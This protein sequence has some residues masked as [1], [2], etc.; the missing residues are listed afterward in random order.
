MSNNSLIN[1]SPQNIDGNCDLKCSYSF[2]YSKTN[3]TIK[4]NDIMLTLTPDVATSTEVIFNDNK[5]N[6]SQ[7]NIYTPSLHLF[8]G[9][10]V[11][12]EIQVEH[13]PQSGGENLYICIPLV[14]GGDETE[15]S[16]LISKLVMHSSQRAPAKNETTN[17]NT[18]DFTLKS[19][20]PL[21]PFY[22]YTGVSNLPGQFI[23]YGMNNGIPINQKLLGILSKII[24]PY[25]LEMTGGKLFYNPK[26]PRSGYV[27][28]D[29]IYIS[30]KPTGSSTE[31]TT[32]ESEKTNTSNYNLGD[33]FKSDTF[34][35]I[36][37]IIMA[38][39]IFIVLIYGLNMG[40]TY[41]MTGEKPQL[42]MPSFSMNNK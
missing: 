7:I 15:A 11:A 23:V 28:G 12:G 10:K 17:L 14:N 21:K 25:N 34:K 33:I 24:K 19:I 22:N 9:R 3:L 27:G 37:Q 26:G 29:G 41:L 36:V 4:N 8:N 18:N 30:C 38:S 39:L 32:V 1:I 16:K 40:F 13:I 20:I 42:K 2:N 6:V 35:M 5:Y 31:T